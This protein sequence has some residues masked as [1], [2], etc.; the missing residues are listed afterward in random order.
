ML[1]VNDLTRPLLSSLK[2]SQESQCTNIVLTVGAQCGGAV[3]SA[4]QSGSFGGLF[5]CVL[6]GDARQCRPASWD[7]LIVA[8]IKLV[9]TLI[10]TPLPNVRTCIQ[11]L[12]KKFIFVYLFYNMY[13]D[14]VL[15]F[16][17][18]KITRRN[19]RKWNCL[20]RRGVLEAM[21][22]ILRTRILGKRTRVKRRSNETLFIYNNLK[23]ANLP[24]LA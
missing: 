2:N 19:R 17:L 15:Y 20:R 6:G 11:E 7:T 23:P 4:N 9:C 8:L 3:D 14:C 21:Q 1:I 16:R 5:A 18:V 13:N 22:T 12:S 24:C 10:Q